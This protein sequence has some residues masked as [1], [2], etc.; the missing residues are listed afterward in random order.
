MNTPLLTIGVA[1]LD[2]PK[3]LE[4]ALKS[5]VA[6]AQRCDCNIQ[7]V[8]S[9]MGGN[10]ESARAYERATHNAPSWLHCEWI[11]DTGIP[12]GI[13]NWENCL[14]RARGRYFMMIGD[15]DRLLP[16]AFIHLKETLENRDSELA[17]LLAS[18][19][20]IDEAGVRLRTLKNPRKVHDGRAFLADVVTRKLHLRWCAFVA[21]TSG[22][23]KS[24]PFSW[25]FPGGGGAADGAAIISTALSGEIITLDVPISEFRVHSGNDS[26]A[27][28]LSYQHDQRE[29]LQQFVSS[30]PQA[31]SI[32]R[33]LVFVWLGAGIRYQCLRWAIQ[34]LLDNSKLKHLEM[35]AFDHLKRAAGQPLPTR[36]R[37]YQLRSFAVGVLARLITQASF[38]RNRA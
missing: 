36:V 33:A 15:D 20:D 3:Y 28:S 6:A 16:E 11:C 24:R 5:I 37:L 2:R 38:R 25:P 13:A 12:S 18:A 10:P 35:M 4:E 19:C 29:T 27:V 8:V 32:D 30:L 21:K 7:L 1:T 9:D 22:L 31:T 23:K 26:R 17:G 34:G 14:V